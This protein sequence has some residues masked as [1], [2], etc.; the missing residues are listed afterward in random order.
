MRSLSLLVFAALAPAVAAQ[1][2]PTQSP[3]VSTYEMQ[4]ELQPE[5]KTITGTQTI[6]WSNTTGSPTSE[7]QFHLYINAFR[8][9]DSTFMREADAELRGRWRHDEFGSIRVTSMAL[10]TEA[11]PVDLMPGMRP[12]QPD[13]GNAKDATVLQVPLPNPVAPGEQIVLRTRFETVLPKAY[14]RTGYIPGQ[15]YFCMHWYPKLGVLEERDGKAVWNCHQFHANTEFFA[16]FSVY[17]VAITVPGDFVVGATGELQPN[18]VL[19]E[20]DRK[21]L[22]F[23]QDDVHDFAWVADPDFVRYDATFG[24]VG[25]AEDPVASAV[26]KRLGVPASD[27]DLPVTKIILLL[28]P[29]HDN[30]TQRQRHIEAVQCALRFFGLRYG[31]YPYPTIT[32]VDPGR[33]ALGQRL[34]GGMEYPTLI[35]CGT[36]LFPHP[37]RPQ[38]EGVTVHEFGHQYWYGLSANNEFEESW[39]DEGLNSYSEGRAQWLWYGDKMSPV[40]TTDFGVLA[41]DGVPGALQPAEGIAATPRLPRLSDLDPALRQPFEDLRITGTVIPESPLLDVL[42]QQPWLSFFREAAF[43]DALSDRDRWL[44]SDVPDAMVQPGWLYLSRES[45]GANSYTRPATVLRTLERMVGRDAWW[46]FLRR[47]H[48]KA[49]FAHP[50]TAEFGA[51]LKETCGATPAAFFEQAITA[52]ADFDYGVHSVTPRNGT[53]PR[54]EVVVRRYGALTG[55]VRVRFRF[56]GRKEPVYRQVRGDDLAPWTRFRFDDGDEAEPWGRLLEVWVDPPEGTPGTGEPFEMPAAPAG[57]YLMDENLLN[58]AW[59]AEHDRRPA[60]YRGVRL[61]LQTQSQLSFAGLIG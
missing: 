13:D 17:D 31:P 19:V 18:R 9:L 16:D 48:A 47:F 12:I 24:P 45:Y 27:F 11:G 54:K 2:L 44:S 33:D 15:G 21:T 56:E 46:A 22:V 57:V 41:I 43:S 5:A 14:R 10:Q 42:R 51:L 35:T 40:Q 28:R 20:G 36:S 6:T 34:G 4:V 26:A 60:L 58:N 8:D 37:R 30:D 3:R 29:E 61:M 49:R 7:L 52:R 25:A 32:V 50:T 23:H 55:D 39:L 59:R 53:G 1:S 38:P